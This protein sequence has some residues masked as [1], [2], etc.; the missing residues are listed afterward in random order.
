MLNFLLGLD[1]FFCGHK[2]LYNS[3]GNDIQGY[4]WTVGIVIVWD[5]ITNPFPNFN[6]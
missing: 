6:I 5:E 4:T 1:L 2:Y 3:F